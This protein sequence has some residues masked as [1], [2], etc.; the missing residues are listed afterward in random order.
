MKD[1]HQ[2]EV[3]RAVAQHLSFTRAAQALMLTQSAVSHQIAG[4]ERHFGTP[5]F[6]REGRSITLTPA[7]HTLAQQSQ[8]I[9]TLLDEVE[10]AVRHSARPDMG[11][12]RIGA[13]PTACQYLIPESLR[14][15][16]ESYPQYSLSITPGDSPVITQLLLDGQIDLGIVI[17]SERLKQLHFVPLF[18]DEL[19]FLVSA[20]HP[21]ARAGKVDRTQI[22]EQHY[23]LYSRHSATFQ[24][25]ER[26]FANHRMPLRNWT[27]LGSMEAIKEI[28][29]LGLG[30]SITAAWI[31]RQE[32][33]ER[34]L[35]W[36]NLPGGHARRTWCIAYRTGKRLSIAE[37]TF[38]GLC[39]A[40]AAQIFT[41]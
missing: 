32:L 10:E 31:A 25:I 27:E 36:L 12:L 20:L 35:V 28:V 29:K 13:S 5:L 15:F 3:F 26:Y 8:Q 11:K 37:Q 22:A 9:L 18:Q 21:W 30:V 33:A 40:V 14:E 4:L 39:Q 41:K 19:G 38:I 23:I 17:K 34:S 16:R 1:M 7:G 6:T 2:L 24:T